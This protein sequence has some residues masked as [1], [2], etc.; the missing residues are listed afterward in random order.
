MTSTEQCYQVLDLEP[1][2]SIEELKESYRDLV[3][4]WHPDRFTN[5]PRLKQKAENKLK[6]INI[7]HEYLLDIISGKELGN[8]QQLVQI[9]VIPQETEIEVGDC[10]TFSAIGLDND[11]SPCDIEVEWSADGGRINSNGTFYAYESGCFLVTATLDGITGSAFVA[12]NQPELVEPREPDDSEND[13]ES[14]FEYFPTD[15]SSESLDKPK[16]GIPW[17]RLVIWGWLAIGMS[18]SQEFSSPLEAL[19]SLCS[20]AWIAGMIRPGLVLKF[21]LPV[22]RWVVTFIYLTLTI[23][24][25]SLSSK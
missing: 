9:I 1:G 22:N 15:Q 11:G 24:L 18:T 20:V 21:G 6:S 10:R 17:I 5:N 14:D 12:V 8:F 3:T 16:R 19:G 7:S 13:N 23:G 4:V 2:A 25:S